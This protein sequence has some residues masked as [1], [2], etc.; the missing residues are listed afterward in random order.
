MVI[1]LAGDL[2]ITNRAV[3]AEQLSQALAQQ[4]TR[5]VYDLTEVPYVDGGTLYLLMQAARRTGHEPVLMCPS[6]LVTR[7]LH[8]TGLETECAITP[9]QQPA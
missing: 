6:P 1:T 9:G 4:P 3:L 7:L 5:L 2:D 8:V